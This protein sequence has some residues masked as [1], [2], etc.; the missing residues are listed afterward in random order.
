MIDGEDVQHDATFFS[1]QS[2]I[3][4]IVTHMIEL[5]SQLSAF[6]LHGEGARC[7]KLKRMLN[8]Q[9]IGWPN[10]PFTN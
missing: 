6:A 7:V 5:L 3:N 4:N 9:L 8:D 10:T 1:P 2:I